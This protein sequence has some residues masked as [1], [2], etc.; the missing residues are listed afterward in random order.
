MR[1]GLL[2]AIDWETLAKTVGYGFPKAAPSVMMHPSLFPNPNL[3]SFP[4]SVEKAKA[5]LKEGN[6]D[7]SRKLSSAGGSPRVPRRTSTRR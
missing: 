2:S 4:F 1:Q 7:A 3:P 6:W 5:L